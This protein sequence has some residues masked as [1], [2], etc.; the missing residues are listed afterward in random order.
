M[1]FLSVLCSS[2]I[3]TIIGISWIQTSRGVDTA[4]EK[5]SFCRLSPRSESSYILGRAKR[6]E[7]LS[8]ASLCGPQLHCVFQ[9]LW[10][11]RQNSKQILRSTLRPDCKCNA[12]A[13]PKRLKFTQK[14]IVIDLQIAEDGVATS[15]MRRLGL[16]PFRNWISPTRTRK[17]QAPWGASP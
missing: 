3:G 12:D 13:S 5:S 9:P 2:D 7:R 15:E 11:L 17:R 14:Q 6:I 16:A 4:G 8:G 10:R 1:A